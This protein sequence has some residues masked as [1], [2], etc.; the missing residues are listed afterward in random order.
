MSN[1]VIPFKSTPNFVPEQE[2]NSVTEFNHYLS[3]WLYCHKHGLPLETIVR[4]DWKT[5]ERVVHS[6][7]N[8]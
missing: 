4:K 5:W 6:E 1:V 8:S 3:A 7:K 2:K